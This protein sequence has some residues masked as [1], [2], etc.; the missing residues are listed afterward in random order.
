MHH[1][2]LASRALVL[3]QETLLVDFGEFYIG[4]PLSQRH[5]KHSLGGNLLAIVEAS[6]PRMVSLIDCAY[7]VFE[8]ETRI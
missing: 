4:G 5:N 2:F 1:E 3:M 6:S 8:C 7:H